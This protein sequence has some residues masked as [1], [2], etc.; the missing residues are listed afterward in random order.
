MEEAELL[1]DRI[2]IMVNGTL[3][4]LGTSDFIKRKFAVGYNLH[5]AWK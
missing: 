2:C 1:A 5:I 3:L 4:I